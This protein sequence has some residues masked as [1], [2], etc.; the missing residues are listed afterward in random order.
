MIGASPRGESFRLAIQC[1]CSQLLFE[2]PHQIDGPA[3]EFRSYRY[4]WEICFLGP[5]DAVERWHNCLVNH[6]K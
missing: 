4:A 6:S 5:W 3:V 2:C 1:D